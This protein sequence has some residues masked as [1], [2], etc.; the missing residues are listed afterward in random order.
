MFAA[1]TSNETSLRF[2]LHLR[3]SDLVNFNLDT[4]E[5]FGRTA[6]MIAPNN[7]LADMLL[8]A[9]VIHD[10]TR[11]PNPVELIDSGLR[12]G[13]TR[14]FIDRALS[15]CSGNILLA[16]V[17]VSSATRLTHRKKAA[18][19][20]AND[21]IAAILDASLDKPTV[22][23]IF[24]LC[25]HEESITKDFMAKLCRTDIS[26]PFSNPL[27]QALCHEALCL[28]GPYQ[29]PLSSV[30][31]GLTLALFVAG[32]FIGPTWCAFIV[33]LQSVFG[34]TGGILG[35][36]DFDRD[37]FYTP[38]FLLA[39]TTGAN[40]GFITLCTASALSSR[41]AENQANALTWGVFSFFAT[42]EPGDSALPRGGAHDL[43]CL[44][45]LVSTMSFELSEF[46]F[47]GA[48]AFFNMENTFDCIGQLLLIIAF[49]TRI[50]DPMDSNTDMTDTIANIN[51]APESTYLAGGML[52]CW[53][54]VFFSISSEFEGTAKLLAIVKKIF[55]DDFVIFMCLLGFML[56]AFGVSASAMFA[57]VQCFDDPTQVP[58]SFDTNPD[59]EGRATG[60]YL[61]QLSGPLTSAKF[62]V[63]QLIWPAVGV[64]DLVFDDTLLDTSAGQRRVYGPL[65]MGKYLVL[66]MNSIED[67][68]N[69]CFFIFSF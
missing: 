14:D 59:R 29:E 47:K 11:P 49:L 24:W 28:E 15:R 16:A 41:W 52:L 54:R 69:W 26:E 39:V 63:K 60:C 42:P 12:T 67:L 34:V 30:G 36:E 25:D 44:V 65:F 17:Q 23:A 48:R 1:L 13:C 55:F 10:I 6:A 45:G 4:R 35:F 50:L 8:V 51:F 27:L 40:L 58:S 33:T 57:S 68:S 19:E 32:F 56:I 18:L 46:R 37:G 64:D 20:A 31:S 7:R 61:Q 9:Q 62:V 3:A 53:L 2:L 66:N 43:L 38:G 21:T 5:T 22:S